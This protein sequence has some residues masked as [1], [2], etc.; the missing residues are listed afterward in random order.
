MSATIIINNARLS[1]DKNLFEPNKKDKRTCNLITS[2][3]TTYFLLADGKKTPIKGEAGLLAVIEGELK[4]KF[5]GKVPPKYE[6]WA[7]RRNTDANSAESGE[8]YKGYE[9]DK[10]I[11]FSPSRFAKQGYP[12]FVRQTNQP[13]DLTS[14]NGL[15]EARNLFYGGCYVNAKIN[16]AAFE[17]KEDGVTKRGVTTFLE[18]LQFVRDG[19]R[20]GGGSAT[21]EGFDAVE[22]VEEDGDL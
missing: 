8:R 4:A 1:F 12:A 14:A 15:D 13:I 6:N 11:Y 5:N 10:G 21:A 7:I 9:D 18:A 20:F 22:P 16:L 17:T 3:E 2:D 19:E